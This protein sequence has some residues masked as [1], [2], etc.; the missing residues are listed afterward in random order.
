MR[1]TS[2]SNSGDDD[3]EILLSH[4][5]IR[6]ILSDVYSAVNGDANIRIS[7]SYAI[8]DAVAKHPNSLPS[9][10]EAHDDFT[11]LGWRE[12]RKD[13]AVLHGLMEVGTFKLSKLWS[14]NRTKA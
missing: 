1:N 3:G 13:C 6:T 14:G 9:I 2:S 8:I 4:D 7:E 12:L 11:L 5:D 10:L